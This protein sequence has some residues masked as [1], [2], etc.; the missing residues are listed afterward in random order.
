MKDNNKFFK[1]SFAQ[2][3]TYVDFTSYVFFFFPLSD[4]LHNLMVEN[5]HT[6]SGDL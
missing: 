6:L 5:R 4:Q 2:L 3:F 1:C